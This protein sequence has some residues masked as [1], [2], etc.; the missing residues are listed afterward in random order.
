MDRIDW[1]G[2]SDNFPEELEHEAG[3]THLGM[4]LAWVINNNLEAVF[5]KR[6]SWYVRY[7]VISEELND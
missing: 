6:V 5:F 3:G 4:F 2:G 7:T 1:H